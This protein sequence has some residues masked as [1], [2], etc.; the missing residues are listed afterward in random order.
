MD[1]LGA[2]QPYEEYY[3]EFDFTNYLGTAHID[4][5]DEVSAVEMASGED[6]TDAVTDATRQANDEHIVYVW[7]RAGEDGCRY[8][9]NCRIIADDA[10][11]SKYELDGILP[12]V[13]D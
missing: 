10:E 5:I 8:K 2:K 13:E 1:M 12:V 4:S 6:E 9:L 11:G 7:I 3:V